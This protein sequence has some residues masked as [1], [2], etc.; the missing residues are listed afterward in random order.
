MTC[1]ECGGPMEHRHVT[2]RERMSG[3]EVT[4]SQVPAW[5]CTTCGEQ[6]ISGPVLVALEAL[7][8]ALTAEAQLGS[9]AETHSLTLTAAAG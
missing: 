2:I 5:V 6:E 1:V 3:T 8:Q 7:V 9:A 4:I